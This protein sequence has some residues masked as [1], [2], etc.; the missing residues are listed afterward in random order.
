MSYEVP[1]PN[2][3]LG[4]PEVELRIDNTA[5]LAVEYNQILELNSS[6]CRKWA[7]VLTRAAEHLEYGGK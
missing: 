3:S 1:L 2:C 5:I 4:S 6:D 7:E